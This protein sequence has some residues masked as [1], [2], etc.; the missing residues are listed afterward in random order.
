MGSG[1]G[2]FEVEESA[3]NGVAEVVS[4]HIYD[5]KGNIVGG[6][7]MS[8]GRIIHTELVWD[9][10]TSSTKRTKQPPHP[11]TKAK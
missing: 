1:G 3:M 6:Y 8:T 10:L 9:E 11:D 4:G 2:S 7:V 5:G